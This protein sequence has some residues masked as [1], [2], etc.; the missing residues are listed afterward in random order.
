VVGNGISCRASADL[1]DAEEFCDGVS[2]LCPNDG[3]LANG[4]PCRTAAG[5]CDLPEAC[6]GSSPACPVDAFL[7]GTVEC[8]A[9]SAGEAC[10]VAENCTGSSPDCPADGFALIGTPCRADAGDCDVGE[11]CTGLS[12]ACPAD[13]KEPNGTSCDDGNTCTQTDACQSGTCSGADPLDCSDGDAC[14]ADSCDPMGGCVNDDAPATGCLT[15]AKSTLLLKHATED[16]KDKLLWKWIK[17]AALT[18]MD[19]ADPTSSA[20]YAL[21]I[22]AGTANALIADAAL[23][24]GSG[25]SASGT[26]GYKFKGTSPDGLTKTILKGGA[27]GKSKAIAKGKG[28]TLPDPTLPL[29]YPVTVQ[30]KKDGSALCLESSFTSADEKKNDATQFK[31]K[32]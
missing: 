23:P 28:A 10:D 29:A 16:S 18:Q 32:K 25:W 11:A 22:Y 17:G 1:C 27:A 2:A 26:K 3:V 7:P 5:V 15:A 21:C 24:P 14:S 19:L 12:T 13:A 4:T 20:S 6:N 30:L 8:R 31:A 9:A